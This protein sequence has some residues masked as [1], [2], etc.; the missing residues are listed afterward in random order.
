MRTRLIVSLV[1]AMASIPILTLGLIDPLEGGVALLLG[2]LIG[3]AIRLL[4]GIPV[5]RFA[6]I[7]LVVTAAIGVLALALAIPQFSAGMPDVAAEP[8]AAFRPLALLRWGWRLGVLAV[9]AGAV[10]YAARIVQA[11]LV[12]EQDPVGGSPGTRSAPGEPEARP[13]G[14]D[15]NRPGRGRGV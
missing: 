7:A 9:I 10:W 2:F 12:A 6:W 4:S 14:D 8:Q 13:P 5:P 11:M 3:F 15:L 1:L